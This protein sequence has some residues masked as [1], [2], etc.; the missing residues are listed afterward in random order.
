MATR[1]NYPTKEV[2]ML[3]F[4]RHLAEEIADMEQ[5]N[6]VRTGLRQSD[7]VWTIILQHSVTKKRAVI[8]I[9]YNNLAASLR[10]NNVLRKIIT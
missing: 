1:K 9:D 8:E 7:N 6:W 4:R 3:Q 2:K 10:V 5:C